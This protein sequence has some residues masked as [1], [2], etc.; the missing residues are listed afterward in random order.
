[1]MQDNV[2]GTEKISKLFIKFSIPAILSLTIAGVQTMV[3]GI[4]LGNFV[5][6][7]AMASVSAIYAVNDWDELNHWN[8]WSKLY[9]A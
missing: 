4:F 8:W 6:T 5:G 2:L 3:D 7:N 9:W 1:M